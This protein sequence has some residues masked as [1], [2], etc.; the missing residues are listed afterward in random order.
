MESLEHSGYWWDPR[1]PDTKWAGT[2]RF[3]PTYHSGRDRANQGQ[4]R[5]ERA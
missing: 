1:E 5:A 3:R 4:I 2:L